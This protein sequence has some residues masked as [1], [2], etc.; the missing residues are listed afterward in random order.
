MSVKFD[1]A[2]VYGGKCLLHYAVGMVAM[3]VVRTPTDIEQ[4]KAV[5][6]VD[7]AQAD[8]CDAVREM[9]AVKTPSKEEKS[10]MSV[11]RLRNYQGPAALLQ[12][13]HSSCWA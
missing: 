12:L 2:G 8:V 11:P 9:K 1:Q 5:P 3:I 7:K 6:Q 13:L 4:T 10:R